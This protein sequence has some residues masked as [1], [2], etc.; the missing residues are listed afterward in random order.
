MVLVV[1]ELVVLEVLV[2]EVD[3]VVQLQVEQE[4]LLR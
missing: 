4:I 3:I 2:E 1:A